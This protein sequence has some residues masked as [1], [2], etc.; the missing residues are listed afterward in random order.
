[1][2]GRYV[3][4]SS[5]AQLAALFEAEP[6][7][8][9]APRYNVAPTQPVAVV[10]TDREGGRR[11][12]DLVRWGLVPWWAKDVKLGNRLINARSE[13]AAEKPAFKAAMR[14]RRCLVVADGFYEWQRRGPVKQPHL[15]QMADEQPFAMAGLWEHWQDANG[16]ELETCAIL[17][18]PANAMLS[19]LH[20]R[21]PA[22][23]EAEDYLAWLD[24]RQTDAQAAG[25]LLRPMA[26]ERM[27]HHPV[28]L[29]V[30]N[31]RHDDAR[32][33]APVGG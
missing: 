31:P 25:A 23:L 21:M 13:T 18:T 5:S 14:Y 3:I 12:L 26:A 10:R 2:C 28:S 29:H 8:R 19:K 16:N 11:T 30:N 7:V 22:I 20:E 17:T 24:P 32:C 15:I 4:T 9:L 6:R 1:M 27:M 33:V